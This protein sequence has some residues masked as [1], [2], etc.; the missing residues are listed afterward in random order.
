MKTAIVLVNIGQLDSVQIAKSFAEVDVR[1]K[2]VD[3][4]TLV[5]GK[6]YSGYAK[7]I[8]VILNVDFREGARII[9]EVTAHCRSLEDSGY[10]VSGLV[11]IETPMPFQTAT[12]LD[13][14]Y[15]EFSVAGVRSFFIATAMGKL[16][17][18]IHNLLNTIRG[19]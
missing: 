15:D 16:K 9:P 5:D 6:G 4:M 7:N 19:N 12:L 11:L 17:G 3:F 2:E 8:Y 1:R 18:T 14:I 13:M 10:T